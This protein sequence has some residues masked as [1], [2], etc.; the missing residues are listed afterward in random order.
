M[1]Q[2]SINE[3]KKYFNSNKIVLIGSRKKST[4]NDIV[5]FRKTKA[6]CCMNIILT[7]YKIINLYDGFINQYQVFNFNESN[8]EII[9]IILFKE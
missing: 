2:I 8:E 7:S 1:N 4:K 6:K 9:H 3:A 5:K